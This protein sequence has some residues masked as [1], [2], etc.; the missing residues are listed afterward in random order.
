MSVFIIIT[1]LLSVYLTWS[2]LFQGY[3]I[4]NK[5]KAETKVRYPLIVVILLMMLS[6]IPVCGILSTGVL[7]FWFFVSSDSW[8]TTRCV[9]SILFKKI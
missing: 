6:V 4:N 2:A 9:K 1:I 8:D 5:T 7:Y 3:E